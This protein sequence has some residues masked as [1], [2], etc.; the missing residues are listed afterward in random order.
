M[1]QVRGGHAEATRR[2][3][4]EYSEHVA[5]FVRRFRTRELRS[6]FDVEDYVQEVWK[7]FFQKLPDLHFDHPR[8]LLA[9]LFRLSHNQVVGTNVHFLKTLKSNVRREISLEDPSLDRQKLVSV[10]AQPGIR[11][12]CRDEI[13]WIL[14]G[15]PHLG[16]EI[17]RRLTQGDS[18]KEAAR[19]LQVAEKTVGRF[20]ES[21]RVRAG[22]SWPR[23]CTSFSLCNGSRPMLCV[24]KYSRKYIDE[25]QS[26]MD[27]Q[28]AAYQ[29]VIATARGGAGMDPSAINSAA[30]AFE[31]LFFN[32]MVL[33]LD[34][35]FVHRSRTIEG[36]DSNPLN[37]VR[38]L[39][40]SI[41]QHGGVLTAD[42]TIK[43]DP[44][45]SIL[46]RQIGDEIKLTKVDFALL[47]TAF[48]AEVENRF[49]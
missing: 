39:C 22:K 49:S 23:A 2:F 47:C 16:R 30:D 45:K 1:E 46:K 42:K 3:V 43:Y 41:L 18:Q 17:V 15:S 12:D 24:N 19:A 27:A 7:S 26:R 6:K 44:A 9:F 38:L 21:L 20:M 8:V 28:T 35:C 31:P 11:V 37:E 25:C 5:R 29:A 34:N 33:L 13:D 4:E 40:N 14:R 10:A 48:F 32:S 36:K